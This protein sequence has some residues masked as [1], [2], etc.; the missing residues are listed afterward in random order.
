LQRCAATRAPSTHNPR[1]GASGAC[2]LAPSP[3]LWAFFTH[4]CSELGLGVNMK[5]VGMDVIFPMALVS[6]QK[7]IHNVIYD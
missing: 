6:P 5:V 2:F 3:H 1:A 4:F 7:D